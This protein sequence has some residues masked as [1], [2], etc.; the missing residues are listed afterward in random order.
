[1]KRVTILLFILGYI[2]HSFCQRFTQT[3]NGT[4]S[5]FSSIQ[6][7]EEERLASDVLGPNGFE[8]TMKWGP[9]YAV[10]LSIEKFTQE[11]WGLKVQTQYYVKTTQFY[12][13]YSNYF[14][15]NPL[16]TNIED[17]YYFSINRFGE[18]YLSLALSTRAYSGDTRTP[19]RFFVEGSLGGRYQIMRSVQR[20]YHPK[21][22]ERGI[23]RWIRPITEFNNHTWYMGISGGVQHAFSR[24]WG[25]E[26]MVRGQIIRRFPVQLG[27]QMGVVRFISDQR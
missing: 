11:R 14:I 7:L 17:A 20:P 21:V 1:M 19:M 3:V 6:F 13:F 9:S 12:D 8:N 23:E 5:L 27:L 2:I 15:D 26:A 4:L 25:I 10:G 24:K 18:G 22:G 16:E